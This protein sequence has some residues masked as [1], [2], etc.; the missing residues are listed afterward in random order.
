MKKIYF[1]ESW[2]VEDPG[3]HYKFNNSC[4]F[5]NCIEE[6]WKIGCTEW[7]DEYYDEESFKN[8]LY[9]DID[10]GRIISKV[11]IKEVDDNYKFP[12]KIKI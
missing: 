9:H 1:I 2:Y 10:N 7:V 3:I 11:W 6:P 5:W 12:I 8:A 4:E